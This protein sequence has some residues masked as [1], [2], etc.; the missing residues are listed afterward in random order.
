VSH[1]LEPTDLKPGTSLATWLQERVNT[2]QDSAPSSF[3]PFFSFQKSNTKIFMIY[4][5]LLPS[6][7]TFSGGST[8]WFTLHGHMD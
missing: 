6:R 1:T 8:D 3:S 5:A 2:G 7:K 4:P